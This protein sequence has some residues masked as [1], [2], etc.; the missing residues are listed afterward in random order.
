M[1]ETTKPTGEV[2]PHIEVVREARAAMRK[3]L[4]F[5]GI[6]TLAGVLLL[7]ICEVMTV[8]APHDFNLGVVFQIPFAL[9]FILPLAGWALSSGDAARAIELARAAEGKGPVV[10]VGCIMVLIGPIGMLLW[11]GIEYRRLRRYEEH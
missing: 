6:C 3:T 4:R 5:A 7:T 11:L 9:A 2:G 8:V 10:G 1:G